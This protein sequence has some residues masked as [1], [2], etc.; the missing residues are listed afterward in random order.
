M[1]VKEIKQRGLLNKAGAWGFW[2]GYIYRYLEES[3]NVI[4]IPMLSRWKK[5]P[6]EVPRAYIPSYK[7][8]NRK[9]NLE[10]PKRK[11]KRSGKRV[12]LL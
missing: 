1:S 4:R 12:K 8:G 10:V 2:V 3:K 7:G 11:E 6:T 9:K 5:S